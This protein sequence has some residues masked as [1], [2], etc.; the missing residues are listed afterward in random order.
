LARY[1]GQPT[2]ESLPDV[3]PNDG[4]TVERYTYQKRGQPEIVLLKVIGGKHDY[5][6]DL[7]VHVEALRFFMRQQ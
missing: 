1:E 3:D 7:D 5:P 4:K 6:N 2:K